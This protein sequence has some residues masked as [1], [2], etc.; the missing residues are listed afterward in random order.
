MGYK[1]TEEVIQILSVGKASGS[2]LAF[3]LIADLRLPNN[4]KNTKTTK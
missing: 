2:R 1:M 3:G 4:E